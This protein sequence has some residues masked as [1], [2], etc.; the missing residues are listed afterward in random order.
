MRFIKYHIIFTQS[1]KN[2]IDYIYIYIKKNTST[3]WLDIKK[4]FDQRTK[5]PPPACSVI[6]AK[7]YATMD[8]LTPSMPLHSNKA[9]L[10]SM[11]DQVTMLL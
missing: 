6:K 7:G 3:T 10:S 1:K 11:A 5:K 2:Q 4:D 8:F 9:K